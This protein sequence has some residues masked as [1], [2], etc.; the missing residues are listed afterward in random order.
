MLTRSSKYRRLV[1]FYAF[2]FR[3]Q[4][5][6]DL[7]FFRTMSLRLLLAV[8]FLSALVC[9]AEVP[10]ADLSITATRTIDITSQIIKATTEYEIKNNGKTSAGSFLHGVSSDENAQLAWI[11][12]NLEKRD[13]KKLKT[14]K[15][16]V[17]GAP[18]TQVFYRVDLATPLEAGATIKVL[19]RTEVTQLLKPYPATI[20]QAENQ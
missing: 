7:W 6:L 10:S 2:I 14:T 19:V 1:E 11:L 17:Q 12:A 4:L 18:K 20:T 8:V 5:K 9:S 13:G 16:D 3:T 15:V